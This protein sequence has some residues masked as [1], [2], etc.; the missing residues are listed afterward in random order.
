MALNL[1]RYG[2]ENKEEEEGTDWFKMFLDYLKKSK[3]R[4][5]QRLKK[6]VG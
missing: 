3:E 1:E 5:A 6:E 2:Y 4:D